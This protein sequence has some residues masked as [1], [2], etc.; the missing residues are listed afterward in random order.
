MN[1]QVQPNEDTIFLQS[2]NARKPMALMKTVN[3]ALKK[4]CAFLKVPQ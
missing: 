2:F 3:V 1:N 4:N